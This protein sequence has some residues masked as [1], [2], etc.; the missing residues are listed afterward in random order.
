MLLVP[1]AVPEEPR[2]VFGFPFIIPLG[3]GAETACDGIGFD[4]DAKFEPVFEGA[5]TGVFGSSNRSNRFDS[6]FILLG[7]G[8]ALGKGEGGAGHLPLAAAVSN[9]LKVR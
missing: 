6:V 3:G 9:K 1:A 5:A 2:A 7:G 8:M 4:N